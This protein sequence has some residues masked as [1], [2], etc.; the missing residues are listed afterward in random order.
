MPQQLRQKTELLT[1]ENR[2]PKAFS[3]SAD[4]A[5]GEPTAVQLSIK[6]KKTNLWRTSIEK[7]HELYYTTCG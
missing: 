7:K 1:S 2:N 3:I 6:S 5:N 4:G